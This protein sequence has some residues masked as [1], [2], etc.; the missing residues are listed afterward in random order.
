MA[1]LYKKVESTVKGAVESMEEGDLYYGSVDASEY[2]HDK[3]DPQVIDPNINRFRF[4][5]AD[6][7]KETWIVNAGIHCVG[8]GAGGTTVSGDYPYY[9]E[10]YINEKE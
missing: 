6:G 5:P 4:V 10:K 8:L 3:R 7:G 2:I 1:N 9:F